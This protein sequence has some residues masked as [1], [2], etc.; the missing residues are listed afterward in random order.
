MARNAI[1]SNMGSHVLLYYVSAAPGVSVTIVSKRSGP[2]CPPSAIRLVV[3]AAQIRPVIQDAQRDDGKREDVRSRFQMA[4]KSSVGSGQRHMRVNLAVDDVAVHADQVGGLG[5]VL[6][7]HI[8]G[9]KVA[10]AHLVYV[11]TADRPRAGKNYRVADLL[12]LHH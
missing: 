12:L 5:R 8:L 2:P 10:I 4:S 1:D 6:D 9:W 3:Y 11:V 7:E